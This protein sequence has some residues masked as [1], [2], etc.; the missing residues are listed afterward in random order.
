MKVS[1]SSG[2]PIVIRLYSHILSEEVESFAKYDTLAVDFDVVSYR[3]NSTSFSDT[4]SVS[5][6][7]NVADFDIYSTKTAVL[8]CYISSCSWKEKK[9]PTP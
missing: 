4:V 7:D 5:L 1:I 6:V 8:N 3:Q 9:K 2:V